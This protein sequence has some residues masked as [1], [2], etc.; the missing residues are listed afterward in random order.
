MKKFAGLAKGLLGGAGPP[1][2]GEAWWPPPDKPPLLPPPISPFF[3]GQPAARANAMATESGW[4]GALA[5]SANVKAQQE[6][7]NAMYYADEAVTKAGEAAGY[8]Q[9]AVDWDM[10]NSMTQSLNFLL[11]QSQQPGGG[12]PPEVLM[13]RALHEKGHALVEE[14][15]A[16]LERFDY[17]EEK[18]AEAEQI[19]DGITLEDLHEAREDLHDQQNRAE[20]VL[21]RVDHHHKEMET[22]L[23]DWNSRSVFTKLPTELKKPNGD[24]WW[25]LPVPPPKLPDREIMVMPIGAGIKAFSPPGAYFL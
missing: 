22:I 8:R 5:D 20:E 15:L 3:Q 24:P 17:L 2:V 12:D 19:F 6:Y 18:E 21:S 16:P 13:A 11:Q 14:G 10:V 7:G 1:A 4:Y 25:P 23:H 9:A